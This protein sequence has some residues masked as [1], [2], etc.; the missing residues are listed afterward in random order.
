MASMTIQPQE[1]SGGDAAATLPAAAVGERIAA[2]QTSIEK[3]LQYQTWILSLLDSG[4]SP[5]SIYLGFL[6]PWF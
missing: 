4:T 5:L 6:V 3:T 1:A 2:A